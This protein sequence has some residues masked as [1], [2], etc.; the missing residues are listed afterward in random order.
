M[1]YKSTNAMITYVA[2]KYGVSSN[3]AV[4]MRLMVRGYILNRGVSYED[5]KRVYKY[6]MKKKE[7]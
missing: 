1:K 6:L 2:E 3:E 4:Y 5:C 7:R